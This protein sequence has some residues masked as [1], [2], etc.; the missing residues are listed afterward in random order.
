VSADEKFEFAGRL[1]ICPECRHPL[2]MLN[3][4]L[5]NTMGVSLKQEEGVA[6]FT[7]HSFECTW[8]SERL[9]AK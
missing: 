3:G 5:Q 7:P 6:V 4:T 1:G 9:Q 2:I 8:Y